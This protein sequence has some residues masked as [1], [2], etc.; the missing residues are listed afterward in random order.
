MRTKNWGAAASSQCK[1]QLVLDYWLP[2]HAFVSLSVITDVMDR[3][4]DHNGENYS[5]TTAS[6]DE[7]KHAADR[8]C[9]CVNTT[10]SCSSCPAAQSQERPQVRRDVHNLPCCMPYRLY[11]QL[12]ARCIF[13]FFSR[14]RRR[15]LSLYVYIISATCLHC[16]T[17]QHSAP[18][19]SLSTRCVLP[20]KNKDTR[21][22]QPVHVYVYTAVRTSRM[23]VS[24]P[25][26]PLRQ[27]SHAD[28]PF[29][30]FPFSSAKKKKWIDT[31]LPLGLL[32]S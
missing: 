22:D 20:K 7:T 17:R 28:I 12:A 16:D 5:A 14:T 26:E 11:S 25:V 2:G 29:F 24:N 32:R 8:P 15:F 10:S 9:I 13:V 18:S 19:H 31:H 6:I 1:Q 21:N 3:S 4:T 27:A 30:S 23:G